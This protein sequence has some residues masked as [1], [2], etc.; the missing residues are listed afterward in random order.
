VRRG[1]CLADHLA[2]RIE[3]PALKKCVWM[4]F[5]QTL[6]NRVDLLAN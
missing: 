3:M 5:V 6:R 4:L 2:R 1:G